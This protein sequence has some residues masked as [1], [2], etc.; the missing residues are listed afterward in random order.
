MVCT[1]QF[2]ALI[3]VI[4]FAVVEIGLSSSNY[5]TT[6]TSGT[7]QVCAVITLGL[8][9]T[10]ECNVSLSLGT[11]DASAIGWFVCV[12]LCVYLN[13]GNLPFVYQTVMTII[14]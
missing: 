13:T 4:Y 6:E 11:S 14:Q 12:C 10:L 1:S 5:D 7:V 8:R 3:I 2:K 9:L